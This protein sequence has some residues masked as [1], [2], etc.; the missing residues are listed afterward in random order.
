MVLS[1]GINMLSE[2]KWTRR[3]MMILATSMSVGM[4]LQAVPKSMQHL[5]DTLEMLMT[6]GLLPVAVLAVVMNLILPEDDA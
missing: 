3:N 1:A 4:G 2:V 5:P 6:S